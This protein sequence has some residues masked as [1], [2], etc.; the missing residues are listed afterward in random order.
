MIRVEHVWKSYEMEHGKRH[1]VYR[2]LCLTLPG[3]TNIG[4]V[5]RNGA[6]KSTLVRL[7]SGVDRPDRGQVI[8]DGLISPP[9]GLQSGIA[10]NLTGRENAKFVCRIRGDAP[11]T[12]L[13]RVAYIKAFADVG[14]FFEAPMRTYSTGMRARVAFAISMAFDYDYYLIDELTSVGDEGFRHRA[15]AAFD[16]KRGKASI[17]LVSHS[18]AALRHW[19]EVG[20]YV[21]QGQVTYFDHIADAIRAYQRDNQ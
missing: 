8:S 17:V 14:D 10:A 5:G 3:K 1:T 21:K 19:C 7:L 2:D 11:D 4:I 13:R 18:M 16:S 12:M 20:V 15:D 6:G 9:L